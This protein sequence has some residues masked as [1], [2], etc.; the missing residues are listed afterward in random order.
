MP[1]PVAGALDVVELATQRWIL[2]GSKEVGK[3]AVIIVVDM[4][5]YTGQLDSTRPALD[6]LP[7]ALGG[8][9]TKAAAAGATR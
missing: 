8:G 3:Q 4:Q 5:P 9:Q 1:G 2:S 6:P 7:S